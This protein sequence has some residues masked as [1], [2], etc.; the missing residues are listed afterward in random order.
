MLW[1]GSSTSERA[2]ERTMF[3]AKVSRCGWDKGWSRTSTEWR[4]RVYLTI[5]DAN[6]TLVLAVALLNL[7]HV[8]KSA[9]DINSPY[10][11]PFAVSA[12]I[13]SRVLERRLR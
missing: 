11:R 3:L 4:W 2:H 7:R 12:S 13:A 6:S 9:I 8:D 5:V 1:R 10:E